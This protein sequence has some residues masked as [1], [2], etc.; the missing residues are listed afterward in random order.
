MEQTIAELWEDLLGVAPVLRHDSFFDL[1]GHSLLA[2]QFTNRFRKKTGKV[3][4]LSALLETP[5]ISHLARVADPD[6]A[7]LSADEAY[8]AAPAGPKDVVLIRPGGALSPIFFIHD[9]LGETLLYRGLALRL[10]PERP[11]YGIEP[12]RTAAGQFAH[13]S[14]DEMAANYVARLRSVQP[15]GPYLLAGL[16]AGGVIAFEMA[17][18]L[19]AQG[20]SVAFVG[21]ID[22]ADVEADKRSFYITRQRLKRAR[23]LLGQG[24]NL[25]LLPALGQRLANAIAW[26]ARSRLRRARDRQTVRKLTGLNTAGSDAVAARADAPAIGF[27]QLYE[28]AHRAH[29]PKGLFA[30]GEVALFKATQGSGAI[31]DIPYQ[32]IYR[33]FVLGWGRR[34][35]AEVV[36]A[37]VPGGHGSVLQEPHVAALALRFQDAVDSAMH[38]VAEGPSEPSDP[39]EA[40]LIAV[41]AE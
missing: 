38:D 18:Q 31:E 40:M 24:A 28:V 11:V 12:L 20:E 30:G 41:A 1:G 4:P 2:V 8:E 16:C 36:V 35:E 17:Q 10:D 25:A 7:P 21:I 15:H 32:E 29:R 34:V 26:E 14:I 19:R 33:D 39:E 3:L 23:A 13:T 6:S 22:A 9:G 37:A 27:L 5:T